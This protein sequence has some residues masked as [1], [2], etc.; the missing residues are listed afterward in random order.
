MRTSFDGDFRIFDGEIHTF[1]DSKS[2]ELPS[3]SPRATSFHRVSQGGFFA[4]AYG[5]TQGFLQAQHGAAF[6][7]E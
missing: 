5:S 6:F 4:D 2:M 1:D 7:G 3:P